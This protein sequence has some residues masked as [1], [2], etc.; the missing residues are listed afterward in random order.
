MGLRTRA[1]DTIMRDAAASRRLAEAA[2]ELAAT[3]S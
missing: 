1:M 3:L 2:L